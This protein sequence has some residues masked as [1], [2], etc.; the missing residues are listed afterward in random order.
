MSHTLDLVTGLLATA[1]HL[2]GAGRHQAALGLLQRL[3]G[4]RQLAPAVAEEVHS[5]IADLHAGRQE[6][7]QARRHLTIALTFRP[8]HAAYHNRM[9]AWIEADPDAAIDRAGQYY[10]QACRSE[11][12]NAEYWADYGCYLLGSGRPRSGRAA[13]RRA[14]RLASHDADLVGRLAAALRDAG[15]WD[16][17]RRLLRRARFQRGRDRRFL[18][19]WH[20]HQFEQRSAEQH[21]SAESPAPGV[22]RP[23]FLPFRRSNAARPAS[24]HVE[25][26]IIRLDLESDRAGATLPLRKKG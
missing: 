17:A 18:A 21:A 15:M 7:K 20:Q 19:L 25:G 1:R 22:G 3:V 24:L 10:R 13:L 2:Q 6:Y 5:S 11:P 14:F 23:T 8:Q 4:F 26:K 12:D 16:E 9:G